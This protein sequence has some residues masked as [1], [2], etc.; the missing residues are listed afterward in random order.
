MVQL[1]RG[2]L[3]ERE[4]LRRSARDDLS[5]TGAQERRRAASRRRR[6]RVE[7]SASRQSHHRRRSPCGGL[8]VGADN[9]QLNVARGLIDP[10]QHRGEDMSDR[11]PIV[12][13]LVDDILPPCD[14]GL[15][16]FLIHCFLDFTLAAT[17]ATWHPVLP[18][19]RIAGPTS[20]AVSERP[21]RSN[22]DSAT[23]APS[24]SFVYDVPCTSRLLLTLPSSRSPRRSRSRHGQKR[25]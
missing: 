9:E 7:R 8:S 2:S 24:S 5:A 6:E 12:R 19:P 13:H 18:V 17:R 4:Q 10:V 14:G 1:E 20:I 16:C 3:N 21:T 23:P 25:F 15:F 22:V 11:R